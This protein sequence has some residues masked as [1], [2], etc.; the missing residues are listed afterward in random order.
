MKIIIP[1]DPIPQVRHRSFIRGGAINCYDPQH[2]EKED[3][4][5]FITYQASLALD[6]IDKNIQMDATEIAGADSFNIIFHFYFKPP[7]SHSQYQKNSLLWGFKAMA[8]KPDIDN[9]IKFYLDA[10]KGVLYKDDAQVV[11]I[12]AKKLY[13]N[14]PKTVMFILKNKSNMTA[15]AVK[16]ILTLI[17]PDD[18]IDLCEKLHALSK[19]IENMNNGNFN[20]DPQDYPD[21][22]NHAALL[23]AAVAQYAPILSKINKEIRG[24]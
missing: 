1:G 14:T 23:L 24:K 15:D 9:L 12:F 6:S 22:L 7:E 10:A 13:S 21:E 8:K 5:K 19:S 16:N 17:S 3:V 11:K 4:K 20:F 18:F 2:K